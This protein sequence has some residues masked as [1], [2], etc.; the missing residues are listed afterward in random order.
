MIGDNP[1]DPKPGNTSIRM[2]AA[3]LRPH[4]EKGHYALWRPMVIVRNEGGKV[5]RETLEQEV[6]PLAVYRIKAKGDTQETALRTS[7]P[8][9]GAPVDLIEIWRP[10]PKEDVVG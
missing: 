3:V 7:D 9:T 10:A 8:K 2:G 6:G 1:D 5:T 4:D